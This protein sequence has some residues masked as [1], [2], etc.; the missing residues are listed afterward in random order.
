MEVRETTRI[1]VL[2]CPQ[3]T[4]NSK[5]GFRVKC[6]LSRAIAVLLLCLGTPAVSRSQEAAKS[7]EPPES[8]ITYE[9]NSI[10]YEIALRR[11]R[12]KEGTL[13]SHGVIYI[14]LEATLFNEENA[15]T[16]FRDVSRTI[17]MQ[18]SLYMTLLTNRD[19]IVRRVRD[20]RGVETSADNSDS[21]LT[22]N[23][24]SCCPQ[25]FSGA[26]FDRYLTKVLFVMCNDGQRKETVAEIDK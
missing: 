4:A 25:G 5:L 16:V 7:Q 11:I 22:G 17:S 15:L 19:L 14:Y 9:V 24:Q 18:T 2:T 1:N 6:L 3:A 23:Y 12:G 13:G 20:Y 21:R 8:W 26:Q 10:R